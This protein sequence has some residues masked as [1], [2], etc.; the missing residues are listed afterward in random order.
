MS[1]KKKEKKAIHV[2]V[3][4]IVEIEGVRC[5]VVHVN[6]GKHRFSLSPEAY[7]VTQ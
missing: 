4:Q 6:E 1:E 7:L 5:M 2:R 3:G